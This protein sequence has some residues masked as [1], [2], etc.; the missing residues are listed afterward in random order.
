[1]RCHFYLCLSFV[2]TWFIIAVHQWAAFRFPGFVLPLS[3]GIVM[4]VAG[5][6]IM[7]SA[8]RVY[9]PWAMPGIIVNGFMKGEVAWSSVWT[10]LLGGMIVTAVSVVDLARRDVAS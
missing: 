1:M 4:T 10:G 2:S 6:I 3:F 8:W 9:Y 5:F 7:N